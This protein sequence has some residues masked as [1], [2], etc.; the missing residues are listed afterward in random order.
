[1]K[2][3]RFKEAQ[4]KRGRWLWVLIPILALFAFFVL[5]AYHLIDPNLYRNLVQSALSRSL[6]R[7][8]TLGGARLSLWGGVGV[9]FED[10]RIK[11]RSLTF[12]LLSSKR[13]LLKA[14]LLPLLRR[15][16][17]WKRIVFEKPILRLVKDRNGAWNL[18]E[19]LPNL[20]SEGTSKE[21]LLR[22][23][24]TLFG[25]SIAFREGEIS[26]LDESLPGEPLVTTIR[27]FN[28]QVS[29]IAY[30]KAFPLRVNGKVVQPKGEGSF[31]VEATL[32]DIP[33]D[34]DWMKGKIE[35]EVKAQ[36]LEL[37]HFWPYFRKW[38]P[39]KNLSGT[40]D[41]DAHYEGEARG[42]FKT[43]GK[44]KL[45]DVLFDHPQ[46]F[47]YVLT[48]KWVNV[49]F[50]LRYDRQTFEALQFSVELPEIAVRGKGKVY[51]IGTNQMGME[52]EAQSATFD[53]SDGKRFIPFRILHNRDLA[54]H[55]F[56]SEGKGP[57]QILRVRLA[58]KIPEIEHCDQL[59]YAHTLSVEMKI[60]KI[61]LKLPWDFPVLRDLKGHLSFRNGNLHFKDVDGRFLH[62]TLTRANGT[63]LELLQESTLQ[64][65]GEGK[66]DLTD[67]PDVKKSGILSREIEEVL[68]PI[69]S[70]SGQLQCRV[71]ARGAL[72]PPFRFEHQGTYTFSMVRFNHAQ[73]PMAISVIDGTMT[74][75][76]EGLQWS[77]TKVELGPSS[78]VLNGFLKGGKPSGGVEVT[79]KGTVDL[80][81]LLTLLKSPLLSEDIRSKA[82]AIDN[83][84]GTGHLNF[85]ATRRGNQ[86]TFYFEGDFSP[87]EV[88]LLPKGLPTAI[89]LKEGTLSFSSLGLG[90]S[91]LKVLSGASTLIL[92]GSIR[93]KEVRLS[94]V[95]VAELKVLQSFLQSPL[96][97]E[98]VRQEVS[99]F[100]NVS[101]QA[102]IDLKWSGET[103]DLIHALKEG[104]IALKGVSF[105][106][107]GRPILFSGLEGGIFITPERI[108]GEGLRGRLEGSI[109]TVSGSI[110]KTQGVGKNRPSMVFRMV[111]PELALDPLL[112]KENGNGALSFQNL[113]EWLRKWDLDAVVELSRGS[114]RGIR[115]QD[116]RA[117]G[118]T[119][120][121]RLRIRTFQFKAAGGDFWSEGWVAPSPT[122][123]IQ[124]EIRPRVSNME[125]KAFLRALTGKGRE[126]KV[127]VSGRVHVSK[128]VLSGEGNDLQEVKA[129]LNGSLRL[130]C[131]NGVIERFNILSK[132]FSVLNVSQLFKLRFPDLK[133]KGLPFRS[134]TANITVK[135]GVASTEDFLVDSDAMRITLVGKVD[136]KKSTI[137]AR[138]G[139]H[140][141]G[142]VDTVLSHV[143][144]VG[145]ILTGKE[146][147]FLSVVSEV[148]GDLDDPKVEAIPLKSAGEGFLGLLKRILETPIRPFQ[149][150]EK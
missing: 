87:K 20:P 122:K 7:E 73:I 89:T 99:R 61:L 84:S 106:H 93:N 45:S 3:L 83:L 16:V 111:S 95:G 24:S 38:L 42:A 133:T 141:L 60:H 90:F 135:E 21:Q 113:G 150:N 50:D 68:Q 129:S 125:A 103:S 77:Q 78:L 142:T 69:R 29:E 55:L 148:K 31:S 134:I 138:V 123:G 49:G 37:P 79:A 33:E 36:G 96:A 57:V 101:G 58:G 12:D 11:D 120:H 75:S 119:D 132:V 110:S 81:S 118:R 104:E 4:S 105:R 5:A 116:L 1:M 145:Y 28:L 117:E 18:L 92:D 147:A 34:L 144:I 30:G 67:L 2:R 32:H 53:L 128:V 44:I 137:D 126:E 100:D 124:F 46:V 14:K 23:L 47:S 102:E 48:P 98:G 88:M 17:R 94:T 8:V 139:V 63:F 121:E 86:T 10:L 6:G 108:R 64:V 107:Q 91:R 149:K 97:P 71:S 109:V 114:Y 26:I 9:V 146:K 115:F 127:D 52:A 59:R 74:F 54:D 65:E 51:G 82:K 143:P 41:L 43:S 80:G 131:L 66:L 76:N 62:S 22:L 56:R 130:E 15:E 72:K 25:G 112:P 13:L 136:L 85:K 39:V 70:L 40:L 140:P 27:S 19:G 35:A